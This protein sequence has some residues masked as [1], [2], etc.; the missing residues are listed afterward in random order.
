[1]TALEAAAGVAEDVRGV[2]ARRRPR[3]ITLAHVEQAI[4]QAAVRY[5]RPATSTTTS[6]RR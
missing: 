2:R 3:P 1:L 6:P 4:A 5:D